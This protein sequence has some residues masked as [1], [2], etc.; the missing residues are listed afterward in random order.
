M[1][2]ILNWVR[3]KK[4]PKRNVNNEKIE[5]LKKNH[6]LGSE[7]VYLGIPMVVTG[8]FHWGWETAVPCLYVNYKDGHGVIREWKFEWGE[9]KAFFGD[10]L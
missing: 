2:S 8:H 5:V 6:P 7:V 10:N 3:K 9:C 4:E 1:L